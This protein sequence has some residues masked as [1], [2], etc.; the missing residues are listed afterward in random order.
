MYIQNITYHLLYITVYNLYYNFGI[1][2]LQKYVFS[3]LIYQ[4]EIEK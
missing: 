2:T 1:Y 3:Y 4:T